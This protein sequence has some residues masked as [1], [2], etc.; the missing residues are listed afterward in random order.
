MKNVL[1]ILA[2]MDDE[3]YHMGNILK[4][5]DAGHEV[6]LLT[7]CGNGRRQDLDNEFR[8]N[9]YKDI[10]TDIFSGF[11]TLNFYDIELSEI[12]Y[13]EKQA[14]KLHIDDMLNK[15]EIDTIYTH[16]KHDQHNDHKLVNELSHL[17]AR[18]DRTKLTEF[19]ECYTPG[20]TERGGHFNI[21]EWNQFIDIT[22]FANE[23]VK[24][25]MKY[26]NELKGSNTKIGTVAGNVHFGNHVN[27]SCVEIYKIIWRKD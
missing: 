26:S 5:K 25:L 27:M 20:S 1:F 24:I 17:V 22:D 4:H 12:G 11:L 18:P 19:I 23:K 3:I 8:S 13:K 15:F 6:F 7:V 16:F 21:L 9:A 10:V 2:H 14:I